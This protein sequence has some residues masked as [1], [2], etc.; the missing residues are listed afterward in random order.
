MVSSTLM[1]TFMAFAFLPSLAVAGSA[2][3]CRTYGVTLLQVQARVVEEPKS[4][5]T[6]AN[7]VLSEP[8]EAYQAVNSKISEL[9]TRLSDQHTEAA[10]EV[11][12]RKAR[13]ERT[14][15]AELE[16]EQSIKAANAAITKEI[17]H[18][19]NLNGDLRWRAATLGHS[20]DAMRSDLRSLQENMTMAQEF[21]AT[22]LSHSDDAQAAELEVLAELAANDAKEAESKLKSQR[23]QEIS[24]KS[25]VSTLQFRSSRSSP[26]ELMAV[27]SSGLADLKMEENATLASMK[28]MF[29]TQF[30]EAN[31]RC[32]SLLDEQTALNTTR[33]TAQQLNK[34]LESAV[35]HLEQTE[36]YLKAQI[37][38]I[39]GFAGKMAMPAK[40]EEASL[41][42]WGPRAKPQLPKA[43]EISKQPND[44]FQQLSSQLKNLEESLGESRKETAAATAKQQEEYKR[45]LLQQERENEA[46]EKSNAVVSKEIE[47]L[48]KSNEGLRMEADDLETESAAFRAQLMEMQANMTNA[49]EFALE[50]LTKLDDKDAA[51]LQVLTEL[52]KKEAEEEAEKEKRQRL[53]A[54]GSLRHA[55]MLEETPQMDSES[56]SSLVSGVT[57]SLEKLQKAQ[58]EREATLKAAFEHDF[59]LG[60]ERHEKLTKE[61]AELEA[62]KQSLTTLQERLQAAVSHL[63]ETRKQLA[64]KVSSLQTFLH[65]LGVAHE[66]K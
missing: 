3:E 60:V 24:G 41:L 35:H 27:L 11:A 29:D 58:A 2:D 49:Q 21:V 65:G 10:A 44:V 13:Y 39:R 55:A 64:E 51:E 30:N 36:K 26:E 5:L 62:T 18:V 20:N 12:S 25:K 61:Q 46:L 52:A 40:Q 32:A 31:S 28:Q 34:R 7:K 9:M 1:K 48:R 50:A 4:V 33:S 38:A 14:L 53:D 17:H 16:R 43:V 66:A 59:Q 47:D 63:K 54:V 6:S 15:K 42:Q 19:Q 56:A 37:N 8:M 45:Q 22:S 57:E 23:L